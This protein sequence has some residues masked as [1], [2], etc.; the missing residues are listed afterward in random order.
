MCLEESFPLPRVVVSVTFVLETPDKVIRMR[1][2]GLWEGITMK[3]P[4]MISPDA[5]EER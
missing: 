5:M 2:N 3:R 1:V 4:V